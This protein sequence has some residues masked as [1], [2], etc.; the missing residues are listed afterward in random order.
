MA[1]LE[2]QYKGTRGSSVNL[3]NLSVSTAKPLGAATGA[4]VY[5][6]MTQNIGKMQVFL[7]DRAKSAA[8][9]AGFQ[10]SLLNT[11]TDE[12]INNMI[13]TAEDPDKKAKLP[14]KSNSM[15]VA[16]LTA[17][18]Y[19]GEEIRF[20]AEQVTTERLHKY[21]TQDVFNKGG[22][23]SEMSL[24]EMHTGAKQIIDNSAKM[25]SGNRNTYN[26]FVD[27]MKVYATGKMKENLAT[28][29]QLYTQRKTVDLEKSLISINEDANVL[30]DVGG[31]KVISQKF[32]SLISWA[33]KT[34][35]P[36]S[37]TF[38]KKI[39]DQQDKTTQKLV[40]DVTEKIFK[41]TPY[42]ATVNMTDLQKLSDDVY[43]QYKNEPEKALAIIAQ[44]TVNA[45]SEDIGIYKWNTL[46]DNILFNGKPITSYEEWDSIERNARMEISAKQTEF[47]KN[48]NLLKIA[49]ITNIVEIVKTTSP[50]D[51]SLSTRQGINNFIKKLA[52]THEVN[53]DPSDLELIIDKSEAGVS[54]TKKE[55][56]NESLIAIKQNLIKE[57]LGTSTDLL[58]LGT[59][60][61]VENIFHPNDEKKLSN[62]L[63]NMMN[64]DGNTDYE[65]FK[66]VVNARLKGSLTDHF[67]QFS[68]EIEYKENLFKIFYTT[69]VA[70]KSLDDILNLFN[71]KDIN[72]DIQYQEGPYSEML[73]IH[74]NQF[75]FKTLVQTSAQL[76][77]MEILEAKKLQDPSLRLEDINYD[78]LDLASK[79]KLNTALSY[80]GT[81]LNIT[82]LRS[83]DFFNRVTG[84][85][86]PEAGEPFY[87]FMDEQ[88]INAFQLNDT[89][90]VGEIREHR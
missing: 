45:S 34:A 46:E 79:N 20:K 66:G 36:F 73:P 21:F 10:Y 5:D 75:K 41:N 43:N 77:I 89:L 59:D 50:N 62:F 8:V 90:K 44:G 25:F 84:T 1:K 47:L 61:L 19:I 74:T 64:L 39:K 48:K 31:Y 70:A 68:E 12:E 80:H 71:D 35:G 14:F 52:K 69:N 18:A 28:R 40:T 78:T 55:M 87:N 15:N 72:M 88:N 26:S 3:P 53:I 76:I 11:P 37:E 42:G 65:Q 24:D 85:V 81:A 49:L 33:E 16:E 57:S 7:E 63:S 32:N 29:N 54:G 58:Q 22:S 2:K 82:G 9:E 67:S 38:I 4:Q 51:P 23:E 30:Y 27:S 86:E 56:T 83:L 13:P 60:F 17:R 6:A